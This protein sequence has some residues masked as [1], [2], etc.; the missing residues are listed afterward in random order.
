MQ[1]AVSER[2]ACIFEPA[3]RMRRFRCRISSKGCQP[4]GLNVSGYVDENALK[5]LRRNC[6]FA[7][8]LLIASGVILVA[9]HLVEAPGFAILL[10]RAG[11]EAG[12]VGG[13]ADWFAVT[14]LF[15]YPLGLRIPH[16]AIIPNNKGRIAEAVGRFVERNFLTEETLLRKLRSADAARQFTAWLA[17]PETATAIA[18]SFVKA[19]PYI[20]RS[21]DD[22]DFQRF[23]RQSLGERLKETNVAS[24]LG[25]AIEI[26]AGTGEA[27]SLLE[28]GIGIAEQELKAHKRQID[29]LVRERTPWWV[30]RKI[31]SRIAA[32]VVGGLI[33]LL[34]DLRDPQSD[35]RLKVKTTLTRFVDDLLHSPEYGTA[36]DA[37]KN[38]ILD[39]PDFQA[40]L[41]AIWRE[42]SRSIG[43][44]LVQPQ[45]KTREAVDRVTLVLGGALSSDP[46]MQ[47]QIQDLLERV[48]I[49]LVF[50]RNEIGIFITEVV[51][52]WDT[53]VLSERLEL[54]VG[55]DLQY[56][57]MN[58][59][60]VGAIAGCLI[61]LISRLLG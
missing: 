10:L 52:S 42:L 20:I 44:D 3:N 46:A 14:A 37:S 53:E 29:E 45:S 7:T 60:I 51:K 30:P 32:A 28:R 8:G 39:H 24:L 17:A 27:E 4:K 55:S 9:T 12:I 11:S 25:R 36:I 21:I 34:A 41:T 16:T 26:I 23:A 1:G 59:T 47:A 49:H 5:R 18:T 31:D 43:D 33:D 57:R 19:L 6:A 13:L 40:W 22:T 54:A 35:A 2:S 50:W 56:I 38:R 61:F 48:A 58:G 15:R